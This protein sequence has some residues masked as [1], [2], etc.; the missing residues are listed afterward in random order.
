MKSK[1]AVGAAIVLSTIGL[2]IATGAIAD[3]L[4]RD[5]IEIQIRVTGSNRLDK[6]LMM[7][8]RLSNNGKKPICFVSTFMEDNKP[9]AYSI[10]EEE[11]TLE[12]WFTPRRPSDSIPVFFLAPKLTQVDPGESVEGSFISAQTVQEFRDPSRIRTEQAITPAEIDSLGARVRSGEWSIRA[13]IGYGV[14]SFE[15]VKEDIDEHT[16][17]DEHPLNPVVRWQQLLYSPSIKILF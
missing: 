9:M 7:E 13:V 6:Q 1:A 10:N 17:G 11:K 4:G 12:L 2:L 14:G 5:P 15:A 16:R 3:V 8:W